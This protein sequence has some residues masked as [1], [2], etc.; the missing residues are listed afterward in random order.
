MGG[1]KNKLLYYLYIEQFILSF[2]DNTSYMM[3]Y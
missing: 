2:I 3:N 1:E